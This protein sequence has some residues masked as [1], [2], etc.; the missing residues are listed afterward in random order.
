ME[1]CG[2]STSKFLGCLPLPRIICCGCVSLKQALIAIAVCDVTASLTS[3]VIFIY[4]TVGISSLKNKYYLYLTFTLRLFVN[5]LLGIV[6]AVGL[7]FISGK[8]F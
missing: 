7:C 6:G 3:V 1:K 2:F 8:N 5:I 4:M